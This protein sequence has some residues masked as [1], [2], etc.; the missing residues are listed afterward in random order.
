M[1][2]MTLSPY[3]YLTFL[4]PGG[5][6]LFAVVYG[7]KGWP[8]G[9]PGAGAIL[10]LSV[11]SFMVGHALAALA[12][13]FQASWWGHRPGSRLQSSEGLFD[14]AGRYAGTKDQV[15]KAFDSV[16]PNVSNFEAQF[17]IAYLEA[18]AGPLAPK[19]QAFVE[20]I[21]YYRSMATASAL[22]LGLVLIFNALDRDHLPLF[23]WVPIFIASTLLY[24][25][26]FRRFWR[27]VGEYVVADVL[28][29]FKPS[30]GG[31]SR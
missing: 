21:G 29:R 13:F 27:Y 7:W 4:L 25:Y 3:Q 12:N 9:E 23:P 6:V 8:Y 14:K 28:R 22:S 18:Q 1:D 15:T 16:Y 20:Q 10:G 19:L 24:A 2:K 11:A 31:A 30:D 17:G 5:L 26:R